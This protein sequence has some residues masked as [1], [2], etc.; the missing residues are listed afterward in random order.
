MQEELPIKVLPRTELTLLTILGLLTAIPLFLIPE[1]PFIYINLIEKNVIW[2]NPIHPLIHPAYTGSLGLAVPISVVVISLIFSYLSLLRDKDAW[3]TVLKPVI[4]VTA[5]GVIFVLL[6]KTVSSLGLIA[7]LL[8]IVFITKISL[9]KYSNAFFSGFIL[10]LAIITIMHSTSILIDGFDFSSKTEAISIFS[11]EI[12]QALVAYPAVLAFFFGTLLLRPNTIL[13]V[14]FLTEH[15]FLARVFY[16]ILLLALILNLFYLARKASFVILM[17]AIL[18]KLIHLMVSWDGKKSVIPLIGFTVFAAA[19]VVLYLQV[20]ISRSLEGS[21]NV[22]EP[23]V[24]EA[25][26]FYNDFSQLSNFSLIF[27]SDKGWPGSQYCRNCLGL[28]HNLF[29]NILY[30]TGLFGFLCF[31]GII[32]F[33]G[34]LLLNSFKRKNYVREN[35]SRV[36]FIFITLTLFLDNI[37]NLHLSLPLYTTN[38]MLIIYSSMYNKHY[39]N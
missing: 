25:I 22:F 27:G 18:L 36:Y 29:F 6:S 39:M 11:I 15:K 17:L 10:A 12:Y 35:S 2:N 5:F 7:S 34:K 32:I 31:S 21:L 33:L 28:Y 3:E 9:S 19:V 14:S 24:M 4:L 13:Q 8:S 37:I 26:Q 1:Y 38:V 16:I 20:Y 23:R 30:F